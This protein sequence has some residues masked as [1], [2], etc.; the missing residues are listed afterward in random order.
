[1]TLASW[2]VRRVPTL[3]SPIKST[4]TINAQLETIEKY[5][6]LKFKFSSLEIQ[7]IL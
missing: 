3:V 1:V 6:E 4:K 7:C 2:R 5:V